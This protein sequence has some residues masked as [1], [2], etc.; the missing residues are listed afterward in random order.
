MTG[1]EARG[2]DPGLRALLEAHGLGYVLAV[3]CST[4]VR[5]NQG[6]STARADTVATAYLHRL[7]P[8]ERRSLREGARYCDWAW[9]DTG[10]SGDR[11][12][13][14]RRNL[15]NGELAFHPCWSPHQVPLSE[16][17][18]VAGTGWCIEECVQAAKGQFGLDHYQV[19]HW[20]A[21]P[22]GVRQRDGPVGSVRAS[23][24]SARPGCVAR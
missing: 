15:D 7:A 16:P 2:Q 10:T 13:L 21:P 22:A 19:H 14:L 6:R 18:R 24:W 3:A 1:V 20:T 23:I 4:R 9:I 12:L 8:S 17:V 5:I 11:H